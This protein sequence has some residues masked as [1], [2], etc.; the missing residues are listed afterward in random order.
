MSAFQAKIKIRRKVNRVKRI[1][2]KDWHSKNETEAV[3]RKLIILIFKIVTLVKIFFIEMT[4]RSLSKQFFKPASHF[5]SYCPGL[6]QMVEIFL[7]FVLSR[8]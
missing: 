1:K 7:V 8:P 5:V 4:E 6:S 2:L 3:Q